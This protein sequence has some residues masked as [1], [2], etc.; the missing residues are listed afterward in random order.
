M[1]FRWLAVLAVPFVLAGATTAQAHTASGAVYTETN[2]APNAVQKFDRSSDG[3][4]RL[5]GTFATGGDGSSTPG[6]RQGAVAL[7]EDGRTL[8][9]VNSGSDSVTAFAVTPR[10]LASLGSVPSGGAAPVSVAVRDDRV[11]V[12]NSGDTPA[13]GTASVSSFASLPFGRLLRL[14]GGTEDLAAGASGA[15]QVSVSPDGRRLLV[16]ERVSNRLET[17]SLDRLGRPYAP[18]VSASAGT[19]PFG[20]AFDPRGNAIVSEAGTSSVSSYRLGHFGSLSP[21]T[22]ALPIGIGGV[23]WVAVSPDGRF[24]YTGNASGSISGFAIGRDGGLSP[25][26]PG[27]VTASLPAPLTPRDLAFS[28]D[29]RFLYAVSPGGAVFGFRAGRDGSPAPAGSRPPAT[30]PPRAGAA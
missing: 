17:L 24:A 8:Y 29:G 9:A 4:L 18:V 21:I 28:D 26:T 20:F 7:S 13:R 3:S 30:G 1:R 27:N 14:P 25:I 22:S 23:C 6:G 11:Y 5:A 12:L 16:S 10:G 19:T 2:A 15:A